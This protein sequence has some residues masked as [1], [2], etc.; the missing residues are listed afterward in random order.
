MAP[1]PTAQPASKQ[2]ALHVH[3]HI[4]PTAAAQ[5]STS[6]IIS[7]VFIPRSQVLIQGVNRENGGARGCI[8]GCAS[9]LK[10]SKGPCYHLLVPLSLSI[11]VLSTHVGTYALFIPACTSRSESRIVQYLAPTLSL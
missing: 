7:R 1:Y 11:T 9:D 3:T 6:P 2:E 10:P 5:P 4:W 8:K